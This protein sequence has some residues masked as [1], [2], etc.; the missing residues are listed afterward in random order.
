MSL[1]HLCRI[2]CE[3]VADVCSGTAHLKEIQTTHLRSFC[4]SFILLLLFVRLCVRLFADNYAIRNCIFFLSVLQN[5]AHITRESAACTINA[6]IKS[7]F[8]IILPCCSYR[9][10]FAV[11]SFDVKCCLCMCVRYFIRKMTIK[12]KTYYT[13]SMC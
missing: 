13:Q 10:F 9:S 2:M 1:L 6:F 4:A 11:V 7:K 3:R 5:T 12:T 8:L